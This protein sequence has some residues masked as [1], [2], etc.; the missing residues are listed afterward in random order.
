MAPRLK[1]VRRN[2]KTNV[3][4]PSSVCQLTQ[5]NAPPAL[6]LL[7]T[8]SAIGVPSARDPGTGLSTCARTL[9]VVRGSVA[10][11]TWEK[12]TFVGSEQSVVLVTMPMHAGAPGHRTVRTVAVR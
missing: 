1:S 2:G 7:A 5:S 11:A 9:P 8:G 6:L 12:S 4:G 3:P 10:G